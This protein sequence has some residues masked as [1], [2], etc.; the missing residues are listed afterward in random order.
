MEPTQS[1]P[2]ARRGRPKRGEGPHV[3]WPEVDRAL[4][5]GEQVIDPKTGEERLTYPSLATLAQRYGVSRT[6]LWNVS[7][8]STPHGGM[9]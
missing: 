7:A 4:V 1:T 3:P 6:L 9:I 8:A 5:H 2:K